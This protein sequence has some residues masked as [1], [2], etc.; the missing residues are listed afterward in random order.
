MSV[1]FNK[2][3][4]FVADLGLK[5]LN[6]NTDALFIL[7][8]NTAPVAGDTVVD[9]SVTPCVV[10]STSNATEVAAAS[11]YTKKGIQ[12]TGQTFAQVSGVAKLYAAKVLWTAG[13][14]IGPFRYAV[15]FDDTAGAAASRPVIGW[16][17]YGSS[18]SLGVGDTFQVGN[19]NDGTDWTV[20]YPI[21]SVT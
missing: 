20:T 3:N 10:K 8:T 15:L 14:A 19:S 1:P 11:G 16:W 21:L 6:L 7:L 5:A 2:F 9:T 4:S 18:I 12:L 13:A 17:D